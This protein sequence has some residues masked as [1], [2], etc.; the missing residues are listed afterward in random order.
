ME[1]RPSN[2]AIPRQKILFY[3]RD[4]ALRIHKQGAIYM[5]GQLIHQP[6]ALLQVCPSHRVAEIVSSEGVDEAHCCDT[7][8]SLP[9]MIGQHSKAT[10]SKQECNSAL[11]KWL[12]Y[13][14]DMS[15]QHPTELASLTCTLWYLQNVYWVLNTYS[16]K[17]RIAWQS[18]MH[19]E[20]KEQ[21]TD[22]TWLCYKG[23]ACRD[24]HIV[25][26]SKKYNIQ[27]ANAQIQGN[28]KT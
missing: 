12:L 2:T 22:Q 8:R 10:S 16:C 13:R 28:G 23:K 20:V 27:V 14:L 5:V 1:K 7:S 25:S 17:M 24:F 6:Q 3:L 4:F 21:G 18:M 11:V 15:I 9:L 19:T 26:F